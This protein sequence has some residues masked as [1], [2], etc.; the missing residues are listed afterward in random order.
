MTI[1][2]LI[3]LNNSEKFLIRKSI[4]ELAKTGMPRSNSIDD[5]IRYDNQNKNIYNTVNLWDCV[6]ALGAQ[7]SR[8]SYDPYRETINLDTTIGRNS[9]YKVNLTIPLLIY[10]NMLFSNDILEVIH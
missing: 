8:P 9:S 10:E 5:D 6:T 2:E 3:T 7:L 1:R 4:L